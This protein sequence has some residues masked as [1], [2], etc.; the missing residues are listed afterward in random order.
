MTGKLYQ[1]DRRNHKVTLYLG[2]IKRFYMEKSTVNTIPIAP[3]H[4]MQFNISHILKAWTRIDGV[5]QP[6]R[7][8]PTPMT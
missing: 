2:L 3:F 1:T 6:K 4:T 5:T 8:D 7:K